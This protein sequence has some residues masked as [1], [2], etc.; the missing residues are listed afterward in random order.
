[1]L[2]HIPVQLASATHHHHLAARGCP[3]VLFVLMLFWTL[4]T[5]IQNEDSE[6][7]VDGVML[8]LSLTCGVLKP[9]VQRGCDGWADA[10][11]AGPTRQQLPQQR[12][13]LCDARQQLLV[14]QPLVRPF[15]G[16]NPISVSLAKP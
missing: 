12:R 14:A 5:F 6:G 8:L 10:G 4:A 15:E 13:R 2:M 7:W 1:M 3:V 9:Q 16:S 11:A